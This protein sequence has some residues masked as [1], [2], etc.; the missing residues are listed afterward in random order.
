MADL[1]RKKSGA[2]DLDVIVWGRAGMDLYPLPDGTKTELAESF[3]ADMG[4]SAGNIAV[5]LARHGVAVG[6]VAP[7]SDDPVGRFVKTQIDKYGLHDL[8]P[9]FITG[10]PRTSLALA[11]TRVDANVVIYRNDA[12]DFHIPADAKSSLNRAPVLITTGTAFAKEPSRA[13]T[14]AACAAA[15]QVVL[16]L[17]YRAYSWA[18][19]SEVAQTYKQAVAAS[20]IVIG[21]DEEF[22]MLSGNGTGLDT[23]RALSSSCDL[24]IYKMGERGAICFYDGNEIT[25]PIFPVDLKKPFG[26][27]DAY[28]GGLIAELLA[29]GS[30]ETAAQFGAAAAAIVVSRV[31]CASAMPTRNEVLEFITSRSEA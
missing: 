6:L 17:D 4:G 3:Q 11:E 7:V 2:Q 28:M 13:E 9:D 22:D 30:V 31:G 14:F 29:G 25:V 20:D 26:A 15:E 8:C 16:D 21:N 12:A 24:L 18:D 10:G 23:A 27:G 1:I 5:A 19:E